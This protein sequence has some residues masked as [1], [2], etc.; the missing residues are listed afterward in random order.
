MYILKRIQFC[1]ELLPRV[2][3]PISKLCS[4]LPLVIVCDKK[5]IIV[6]CLISFTYANDEIL[7]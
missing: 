3:S 7:K 5:E 1:I 6:T 4:Y 2:F